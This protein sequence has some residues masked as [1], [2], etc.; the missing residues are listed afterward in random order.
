M[1]RVNA[2]W[3][4]RHA[5]PKKPSLDERVAWHLAHA[6][7]CACRAIPKAMLKELKARGI[8]PPVLRGQTK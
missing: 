1:G 7:S 2:A 6:A 3:H 5:M 4:E 8:T